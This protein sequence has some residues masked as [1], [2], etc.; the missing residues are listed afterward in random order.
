ME[1]WPRCVSQ[2]KPNQLAA[3]TAAAVPDALSSSEQINIALVTRDVVTDPAMRSFPPP[4]ERRIIGQLHP[5]AVD[6][7]MH[8]WSCLRVI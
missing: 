4:S 2:H 3:P 6:K 5:C 7:T 1:S 8:S